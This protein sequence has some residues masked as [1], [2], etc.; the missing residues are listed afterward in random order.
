[1]IPGAISTKRD[2][3]DPETTPMIPG[4]SP[5]SII[6]I[7]STI[8]TANSIL[9]TKSTD[10]DLEMTIMSVGM[11]EI[12]MI[13]IVEII[14]MTDKSEEKV[15][16]EITEMTKNILINKLQNMFKEF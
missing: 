15:E 7:I 11:T 13:G 6:K 8:R 4:P 5:K 16:I 12:G 1:M 9:E 14:E 2:I 3:L 10:K